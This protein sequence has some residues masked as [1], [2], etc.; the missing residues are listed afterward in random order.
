MRRKSSSLAKI[1][2]LVL[3]KHHSRKWVYGILD[4]VDEYPVMWVSGPAGLGKTTQV[5]CCLKELDIRCLWYQ[6]AEGDDDP[7]QP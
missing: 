5:N 7:A 4:G 1:T 3:L 2:R 6:P